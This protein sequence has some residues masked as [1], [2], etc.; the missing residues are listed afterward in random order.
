LAIGI[1]PVSSLLNVGCDSTC[2][3][4][5]DDPPESSVS[6]RFSNSGVTPIYLG[7]TVGCTGLLPFDIRPAGQTD[8]TLQ[9][10]GCASCGDLQESTPMC[11]TACMVAPVVRI[12]P[13]GDYSFEWDG[14]HYV[15]EM[16]PDSCYADD[17]QAVCTR[18]AV[19]A[20]G[21]YE[22][23]GHA[24]NLCSTDPGTGECTCTPSAD[25]SC[26]VDG[27]AMVEGTVRDVT[28]TLDYPGYP[29]STTELDFVF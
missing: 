9:H 8:L 23:T 29:P 24:Y 27:A 1:L 15:S 14:R 5:L 26:R 19:V 4:Y 18:Q 11:D 17:A 22:V 6:L 7:M 3:G 2:D 21:S 12:E 25:G 28:L 20:D 13:G 10:H 16:M